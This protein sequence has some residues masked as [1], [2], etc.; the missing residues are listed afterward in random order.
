[1]PADD[2]LLDCEEGT[3]KAAEHLGQRSCAASA[4]A[5]GLR[6]PLVEHMKPEYFGSPTDLKSIAM[7]SVPEATQLADQA[8]QPRP[9]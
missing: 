8:L 7:I 1:M 4:P 5:P 3:E 9:I 2:I 6:P